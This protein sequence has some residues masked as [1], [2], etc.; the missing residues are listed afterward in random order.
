[1]GTGSE[2]EALGHQTAERR[3]G[4]LLRPSLVSL[5]PLSAHGMPTR[6]VTSSRSEETGG[7]SNKRSCQA[8]RWS[9]AS[10]DERSGDDACPYSGRRSKHEQVMLFVGSPRAQTRASCPPGSRVPGGYAS[11]QHG[12]FRCTC[13]CSHTCT[14]SN[15]C[16]AVYDERSA[17]LYVAIAPWCYA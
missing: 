4:S 1:M 11:V 8:F 16:T 9:H 3:A 17:A 5:P 7:G 13:A 2:P 6:Y 10:P 12:C 14:C 15:D